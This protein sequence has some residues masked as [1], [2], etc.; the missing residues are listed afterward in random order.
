MPNKADEAAGGKVVRRDA[1]PRKLLRKGL[2]GG[3]PNEAE[4]LRAVRQAAE[5]TVREDP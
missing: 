2:L 4:R 1:E 5:Q 3:I